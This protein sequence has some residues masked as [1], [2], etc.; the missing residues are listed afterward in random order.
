MKKETKMT[1]VHVAGY[2]TRKDPA[3]SEEELFDV[4]TFYYKEFGGYTSSLDRG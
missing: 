4:T 2:V 3:P 1:L